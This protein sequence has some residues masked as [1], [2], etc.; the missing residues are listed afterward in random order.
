MMYHDRY[1]APRKAVD[2][3]VQ[4]TPLGRLVTVGSE[5]ALHIGLF[6]FIIGADSFDLHLNK[7]DE[8]L[9][10]LRSNDRC[11]FEID[12]VLAVVPS[13]WQHPENAAK[14][15]AYYRAAVF[16]CTAKMSADPETLAEHLRDIMERYQPEGGYRPIAAPDPMYEGMIGMLEKVSL[17]IGTRRAKFKLAQNRTSAVR[18]RIIGELRSRGRTTDDR[19]ADGLEWTLNRD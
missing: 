9:A 11:L 1:A 10:D 17:E 6:P 8:Q 18:T 14:G 19:A 16:E 13:H 2:Q 7:N 5:G 4:K 15:T 3:L 12:E